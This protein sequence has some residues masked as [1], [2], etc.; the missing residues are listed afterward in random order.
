MKLIKMRHDLSSYVRKLKDKKWWD[1]FIKSNIIQYKDY[2]I[3][4][5]IAMPRWIRQ[6]WMYM[7]HYNIRVH[8]LLIDP[9]IQML[10]WAKKIIDEELDSDDLWKYSK[11]FLE[12][13]ENE[14]QY[15]WSDTWMNDI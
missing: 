15:N 3:L 4:V 1:R 11:I 5:D 10:I 7:D 14:S 9:L 8:E 6:E 2:W 12:E 13:E